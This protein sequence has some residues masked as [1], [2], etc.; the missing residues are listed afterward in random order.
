MP[1]RA[2][3][4]LG[5]A[6]DVGTSSA[7]QL[8]MTFREGDL[9]TVRQFSAEIPELEAKA[10]QSPRVRGP[11]VRDALKQARDALE[12]VYIALAQQT[13]SRHAAAKGAAKHALGLLN[14]LDEH[15]ENLE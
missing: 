3:L 14:Q 6:R 5:W 15:C 2:L 12:S 8:A 9:T 11:A 1:R 7:V 4:R 10:E 13:G